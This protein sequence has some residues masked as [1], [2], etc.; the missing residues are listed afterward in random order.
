VGI[1]LQPGLTG[2]KEIEDEFVFKIVSSFQSQEA[3]IIR[4]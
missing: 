3:E 1:L 2:E 4:N